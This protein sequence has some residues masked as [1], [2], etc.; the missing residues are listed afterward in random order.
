MK[1]IS[2]LAGIGILVGL[3]WFVIA[4]GPSPVGF[5][6]VPS[7]VFVLVFTAGGLVASFGPGK[8]KRALSAGL[9]GSSLLDAGEVASLREV[10]QRGYRLSWMSGILG[11]IMSV[12]LLLQQLSDP[13]QVGHGVAGAMLCLCYGALIAEVFFANA[14]QWI[15]GRARVAS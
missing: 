4:S 1:P 12:I 15:A 11:S 13:Y 10:F 14:Q 3:I 7:L 9:R 5:L 2:K 8:V 6:H